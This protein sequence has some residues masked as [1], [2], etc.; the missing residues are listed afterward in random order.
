MKET[1]IVLSFLLIAFSSL[2][3]SGSPTLERSLAPGDTFT[4]QEAVGPEL[5]PEVEDNYV[6]PIC[7]V[8]IGGTT[9]YYVCA[10]E[11]RPLPHYSDASKVL[12]G[13]NR[14]KF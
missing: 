3:A 13:F 10:Q 2:S 11:E 9:Y 14:A 12:D 1:A 5:T 4:S 8:V 7:C 6:A